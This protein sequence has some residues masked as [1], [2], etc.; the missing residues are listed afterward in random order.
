MR[1]EYI[2]NSQINEKFK[3][4][5]KNRIF[6]ENRF[7]NLAYAYFSTPILSKFPKIWRNSALFLLF[8]YKKTTFKNGY[9]KEKSR[10]WG[11]M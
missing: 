3:W 2:T 11:D 4:A 7:D 5:G 6:I 8:L 1:E 10:V 9:E